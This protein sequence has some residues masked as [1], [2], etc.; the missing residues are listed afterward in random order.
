MADVEDLPDN[1]EFV[2][3]EDDDVEDD[4]G[5]DSDVERDK[6]GP[7]GD[8]DRD[9]EEYVD[10]MGEEKEDGVRRNVL[11]HRICATPAPP[12]ACTPDEQ[13]RFVAKKYDAKNWKLVAREVGNRTDLQ[14]A[15]H[16]YSTY[17]AEYVAQRESIQNAIREEERKARWLAFDKPYLECD[18][19]NHVYDLEGGTWALPSTVDPDVPIHQLSLEDHEASLDAYFAFEAQELT[20]D[21][22]EEETMVGYVR[23][24]V[25]GR[26]REFDMYET[27]FGA[28]QAFE[29]VVV[30]AVLAMHRLRR[31]DS[32]YAR[33][34]AEAFDF[35]DDFEP[36]RGGQEEEDHSSTP[37]P[38]PVDKVIRINQAT[39]E[40]LTPTEIRE[41]IAVR[42]QHERESSSSSSMV[43]AEQQL[44][45][46]TLEDLVPNQVVVWRRWVDT[47][48]LWKKPSRTIDKPGN[49]VKV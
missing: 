43:N 42:E 11:G 12:R 29:D 19:W 41:R 30:E 6:D 40:V 32:S 13:E 2:D 49:R 17:E 44:S 4:K 7:K 8:D 33:L 37:S 1:V 47:E 18:A 24:R 3:E 46:K 38:E 31:P 16:Y 25:I 27:Y 34:P 36:S 23:D 5:K 45:P 10:E 15:N 28:Q 39:G 26:R 14:C 9:D 35:D 20:R 22:S 48:H 21:Q